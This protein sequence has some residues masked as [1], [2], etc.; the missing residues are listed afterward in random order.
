MVIDFQNMEEKPVEGFKGGVGI[1]NLKKFENE[2]GKIIL[3]RLEPGASIGLHTHETNSEAI[4]IVSGTADFIYDP[5]AGGTADSASSPNCD[6]S[7]SCA[8]GDQNLPSAS[9]D[10]KQACAKISETVSAG[11]CH[12][13]PKGHTHSMINN[14]E[15]DII[16]FAVIPEQA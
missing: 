3:G 12:Y 9:D 10:Q 16:F 2:L 14:S 7:R 5:E 4:Y 13:C 1:T 11:G 8:S 6:Q 15:E